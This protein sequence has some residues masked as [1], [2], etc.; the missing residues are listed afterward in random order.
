MK[1]L[2]AVLTLVA[3]GLVG[4]AAVAAPASA[5]SLCLAVDVSVNGEGQAQEICL[6]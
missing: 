2:V 6:P 5:A 3:A 1:R 4:S